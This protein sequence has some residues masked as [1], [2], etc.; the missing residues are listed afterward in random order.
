MAARDTEVD[1]YSA[2]YPEEEKQFPID[3]EK[4]SYSDDKH[5]P[6][7]SAPHDDVAGDI[8]LVNDGNPFPEDPDAPEE[9]TRL[10]VR[11]I[12]VGSVL[13]LIVGASNIYLGLKTCM[14]SLRSALFQQQLTTCQGLRSV[15]P[16]SVPS[17][18]SPSVS[19]LKSR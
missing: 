14:Y 17:P 11:A 5:E 16:F 1:L 3:D 12:A 9:T 19:F 7:Q 13:G 2:P 8:S 18:G 10:T 15:P 4:P 6:A